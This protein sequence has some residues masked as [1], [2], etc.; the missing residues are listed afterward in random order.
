VEIKLNFQLLTSAQRNAGVKNGIGMNALLDF[1]I[2]TTVREKVLLNR[3]PTLL[4]L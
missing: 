4:I 1:I 3:V 2:S